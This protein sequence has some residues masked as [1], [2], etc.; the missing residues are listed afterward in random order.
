MEVLREDKSFYS[1]PVQRDVLLQLISYPAIENDFFLTGGTALSAFYLHH[2]VSND[3]DFFT[4]ASADLSEIDFWVRTMWPQRSAK[5]KESPNFLSCLIDETK[6]DFVIDPLANKEKRERV[7]FENGHSL[8]LDTM[9]NISSNKLS[10]LVSR[11][12]PK[13]FLDFYFILKTY[14]ER[15]L[16]DIFANARMKDAIFDDLPTAA[17]Q[18][19]EGLSCLEKTPEI[20]PQILREFNREDF[21]RF[22]REIAAWLY[23]GVKI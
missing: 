4:L 16:E 18:L 14:P 17:Y 1:S 6:V 13:D 2:R 11:V 22:F 10:T 3:L 21:F 7:H 12:E 20:F 15:R 9:A 8:S 19:E 23:H 5:I